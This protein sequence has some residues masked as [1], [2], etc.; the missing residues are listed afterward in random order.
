MWLIVALSRSV[1]GVSA[2]ST[3]PSEQAG[4]VT[5]PPGADICTRTDGEAGI[6]PD[7]R[8]PRNYTL[9]LATYGREEKLALKQRLIHAAHR[10][11]VDLYGHSR[12]VHTAH[13]SGLA[14]AEAQG[15]DI[16]TG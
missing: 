11:V 13:R 1:T 16:S 3:E 6:L 14:T 9:V 7:A 12:A 2:D 4:R 8:F 15:R 10:V 5:D